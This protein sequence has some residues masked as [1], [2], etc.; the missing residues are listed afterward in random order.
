MVPIL[1]VDES[2]AITY[3][4]GR[5]AVALTIGAVLLAVAFWLWRRTD[6][7]GPSEAA[8]PDLDRAR[9]E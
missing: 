4:V 8:T 1:F 7:S 3:D 5:T 2:T 6:W 9:L